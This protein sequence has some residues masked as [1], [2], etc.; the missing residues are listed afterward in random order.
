MTDLTLSPMFIVC[1]MFGVGVV[2][3]I[4]LLQ[5]KMRENWQ[6]RK[7]IDALKTER[8]NLKAWRAISMRDR[9]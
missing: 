9:D 2:V 4:S 3:V 5:A 7:E 6:L 1:L 8:D